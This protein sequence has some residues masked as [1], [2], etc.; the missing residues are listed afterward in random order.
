[1][2]DQSDF[3][4]GVILSVLISFLLMID[5]SPSVILFCNTACTGFVCIT[6][7]SDYPKCKELVVVYVTRGGLLRESNCRRSFEGK[8]LDTSIFC[9]DCIACNFYTISSIVHTANLKIRPF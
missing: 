4:L 9:R 6:L 7:V 8:N 1:M 3:P 2:K 5:E